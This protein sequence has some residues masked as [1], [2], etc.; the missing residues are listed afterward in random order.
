MNKL[1]NEDKVRLKEISKALSLIENERTKKQ[2]EIII[3]W[4]LIKNFE[5]ID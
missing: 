1:T 3:K 4:E 2:L 5:E